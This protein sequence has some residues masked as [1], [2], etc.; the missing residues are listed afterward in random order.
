MAITQLDDLIFSALFQRR[1]NNYTKDPFSKCICNPPY[2]AY[3]TIAARTDLNSPTGSY[4][5]PA[6]GHRDHGAID[7]KV[8]KYNLILFYLV[9][10]YLNSLFLGH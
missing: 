10:N 6:F 8:M 5:Y 2:S 4:I 9:C 1:Y 3:L 7:M